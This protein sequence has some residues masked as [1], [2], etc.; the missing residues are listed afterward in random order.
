MPFLPPALI[1]ILGQKLEVQDLAVVALLV[2]LEGMLSIDNAL[3]LGLLA[4]RLP[5]KEQPKALLYGLAGAFIFR[6]IAVLTASFLLQWTFV[7]L[8]GGAYLVYIGVRHLFFES[9]ETEEDKIILDE[10]G[11]P[12]LVEES[13]AELSAEQEET[14]I[15]E[16]VPVYMSAERRKQLGLA[17]F[18]PTVFVIELTDIAFAVDSILAAIAMV[19]SPPPGMPAGAFHPKL[20]VVILGGLL[21]LILMRFAAR[22]FI[23][24]LEK[25]PRFEVSAYLLV[26][27]IGLKLLAD[28]GVNSDWSFSQPKWLADSVGTWQPSF[29][30]FELK[31]CEQVKRYEDWLRDKWPLGLDAY[32]APA[33]HE[34]GHQHDADGH[35]PANPGGNQA[36]AHDPLHVPH[37][38]NFHSPRRPEFIVFWGL[39]VIC[40][41]IGFIPKKR[42]GE[43]GA[44]AKGERGASAP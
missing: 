21:G 20:W 25:F 13:G 29:E 30:Q 42:Q 12:R 4:K 31:R 27:V 2:V 16:R 22:I 28:W 1:D 44:S 26:I 35:D 11:H 33:R 32:H 6:F 37:L 17:S 3:V 39:M 8:L 5:K 14:E 7:K 24:L 10:H 9:K 15:R 38:L 40:F 43:R 18:W 34:A 36:L 19:G 41:V 23:W